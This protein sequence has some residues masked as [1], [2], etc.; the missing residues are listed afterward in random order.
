L[1][2]DDGHAAALHDLTRNGQA[3]ATGATND[4]ELLSFE[5]GVH[6]ISSSHASARPVRTRM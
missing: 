5:F 3:D 6:F 4:Q 1:A 2:G